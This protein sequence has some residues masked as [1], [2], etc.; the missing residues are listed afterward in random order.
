MGLMNLRFRAHAQ[1]PSAAVPGILI[2][3]ISLIGSSARFMSEFAGHD[4]EPP[5]LPCKRRQRFSGSFI[6]LA[7]K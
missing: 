2:A 7:G 5:R 1:W 3:K 4:C 6:A